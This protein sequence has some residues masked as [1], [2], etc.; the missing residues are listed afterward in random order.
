MTK[1]WDDGQVKTRLG[2]SIGMERAAAIHRLFVLHLCRALSNF[3]GDRIICLSPA[4]RHPRLRL[5]LQ[6]L[7]LEERWQI[8][9]QA[10][11]DLGN[12]MACWFELVFQGQQTEGSHAILI[13]ADCPT[14]PLA[15]VAEAGCQLAS[16]DVVLGPTVDGGYYLIGIAAPWNRTR[17]RQLFDQMP[18]ST[19]RVMPV[20]RQRI[21]EAGLRCFELP[22][23][24]DIDTVMELDRLRDQLAAVDSPERERTAG[25]WHELRGAIE[26]ILNGPVDGPPILGSQS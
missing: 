6:A 15:L 11:G 25:G 24:E 14:I 1:F 10:D 9:A 12:R 8:I 17:F 26:S 4:T 5:E 7:N 22:T 13:G 20:T 2:A 3:E 16:H 23:Y 18:W 19:D 21:A